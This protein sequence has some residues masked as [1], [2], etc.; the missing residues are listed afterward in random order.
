MYWVLKGEI[1]SKIEW[2]S[3]RK[4]TFFPTDQWKNYENWMRN[5]EDMTFWNFTFFRKTFLDQSLWIFKWASWWCHTP[6]NFSY[7]LYMKFWNGSYRSKHIPI[8]KCIRVNIISHLLW[9]VIRQVLYSHSWNMRFL[10]FLYMKW[11]EICEGMT[12]SIA[13]LNIHKYDWSSQC[14]PQ[15]C[16]ISKC[17]YFLISYPIFIIFLHCSVGNI[18]LSLLKFIKFWSGFHL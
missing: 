16:E 15:K 5:K 11:I 1:H 7:I 13:H 8:S 3:K 6:H 4:S 9:V 10:S 18:F 14:F 12:S 2:N 17:H